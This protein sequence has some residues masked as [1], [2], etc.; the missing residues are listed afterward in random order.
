MLNCAT[1]C[2]PMMFK[3]YGCYCGFL[4]SGNPVDGID[5]WVAYA[6]CPES[7]VVTINSTKKILEK[8][9]LKRNLFLDAVKCM[10]SV[11]KLPTVQCIWN[12]SYRTTGN[13][14][15]SDPF[16]VYSY[17]KYLLKN[18]ILKDLHFLALNQAEYKSFGECSLMLCECD[19]VLSECLK[20]Y[21]CPTR[22]AFCTFSKLRFLQNA[23]MF[24][25]W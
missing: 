14:L 17:K 12:I 22:P 8:V 4:G 23:F 10:I 13:A 3:G 16:V 21:S 11:M 18:I 1:D 9:C 25:T 6:D 20:R 7:S 2:N 5:K 24:L 19:R 15:K